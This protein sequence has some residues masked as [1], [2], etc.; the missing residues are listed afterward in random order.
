MDGIQLPFQ[1]DKA[2]GTDTPQTPFGESALLTDY[3]CSENP[4][5]QASYMQV[6]TDTIAQPSILNREPLPMNR[7]IRLRPTSQHYP[8][9]RRP[10]SGL[11]RRRKSSSALHIRSTPTTQAQGSSIDFVNFTPDDS[12]KILSGVAPSGSSKTKARREKEAAERTR[13][14]S[15]AARAAI[16]EAGGDIRALERKGLLVDS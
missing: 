5:H 2:P 13:K 14:L 11:H 8:H 1:D 7:D 16:L 6:E 4:T 15:Q 9:S 12:R 3:A 10:S